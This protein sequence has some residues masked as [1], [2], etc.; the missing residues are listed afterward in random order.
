M[1]RS[2]RGAYVLAPAASID[3][4]TLGAL[5]PTDLWIAISAAVVLIV[6]AIAWIVTRGR[7][8][9]SHLLVLSGENGTLTLETRVVADLIADALSGNADVVAVGSGG[10]R[11]RGSS[12]LSLRLTARRGADLAT[13]IRS[14]GTAVDDLDIV[15]EQR[16]PVLLQV[17]SGVR[18]SLAHEKRVR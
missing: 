17:A 9:I 1:T 12:V 13:I 14:V 10:Y 6:L 15:L 8:R 5:A 16:I 11:M 18:G 7:G 3:L 2:N 4:P